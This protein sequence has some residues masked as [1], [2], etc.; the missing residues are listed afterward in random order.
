MVSLLDVLKAAHDKKASD[1]H[2]TVGNPPVLR[3]DGQLFKLDVE[4]LDS[5]QT[6]SMCYSLI[7]DEQKAKFEAEKNLDFSFFIKGL[8]RFR[9]TL[10]HQK[11]T[12]AGT[13]RVL[14]STP[15][16][17][18]NLNLP[19]SIEN[20]IHYPFG[21]VLITGP[22]GSGKSTTLSAILD[23][24][25]ESRR[26]HI[27]TLED[28]IEI[29]HTHKKCIVNQREVGVDCKSFADGMK[30]ALRIDPDICFI[31]EM[32]DS[33]TV[34]LALKL[35]ETGHLVFST[36]HTN[37]AAK[38][39]DRVLSSFPSNERTVICNQLSTVLQAVISQRLLKTKV[40]GRRVATEIMFANSA[41][42]N[43]IR[44]G[45]IFQLY[46]V[47]QTNFNDGMCTMNSSLLSLIQEGV[48]E[49]KEAFFVSSEKEEL[50]QLLKKKK[51]AS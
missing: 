30:N 49:S 10:F 12:V 40:G 8:T 18:K 2:I 43:L 47:I 16:A 24:I 34:E 48:I 44:E 14:Y 6:K 51:L 45:K 13:F 19:A 46:S 11:A 9:G 33:E 36:L 4:A 22:T 42:R 23:A 1:V 39:I 35:A 38:T 15:P 29:V 3:I 28:P 20:T 7:S 27:L 50:Y 31:G 17:I 26:G 21:L 41:I 32:R 5:E 37:S 25:N